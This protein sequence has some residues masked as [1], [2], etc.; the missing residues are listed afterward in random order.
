MGGSAPLVSRTG[1]TDTKQVQMDSPS[2]INNTREETSD[3]HLVINDLQPF[4]L[5][6]LRE[7]KSTS[8]VPS[9]CEDSATFSTSSGIFLKGWQSTGLFDFEQPPERTLRNRR[10]NRNSTTDSLLRE[11]EVQLSI[12]PAQ[13]GDIGLDVVAFNDHDLLVT[14]IRP[15]PLMNWNDRHPDLAVKQGDRLVDVNG[16]GGHPTLLLREIARSMNLTIRFQRF[17][18]FRVHIERNPGGSL[19]IEIVKKRSSLKVVKLTAGPF[20]DWNS[21]APEHCQ[22]AEG[23]SIVEVN[24]VADPDSMV[25]LLSSNCTLLDVVVLRNPSR[26][27]SLS[28]R[29]SSSGL[30]QVPKTASCATTLTSEEE[31]PRCY[32]DEVLPTP[33]QSSCACGF[34]YF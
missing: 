23:D 29:R 14:H 3:C 16:L 12:P 22:V 27:S 8:A 5:R 10:G 32:V 7:G 2:S 19:G 18:E 25:K 6:K 30:P 17:L 11:F 15:G 33:K 1:E 9:T 26:A 24:G 21:A 20:A 34:T 31:G 4:D 28:V 13:V